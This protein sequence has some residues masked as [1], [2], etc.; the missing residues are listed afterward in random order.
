MVEK[1]AATSGTD[2]CKGCVASGTWRKAWVGGITGTNRAVGADRGTQ[3]SDGADLEHCAA[4]HIVSHNIC[5]SF[6]VTAAYF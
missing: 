2:T 5:H 1:E 6:L 4:S 3:S